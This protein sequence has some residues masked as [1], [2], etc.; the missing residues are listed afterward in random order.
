MQA[1]RLYNV[2]PHVFNFVEDLTNWYV[3]LNRRRFWANGLDEDKKAAYSTLYRAL[4]TLSKVAAPIT[5]F[6]SEH[7]FQ[8]ICEFGKQPEE[9]VHL[10]PYPE[11]DEEI[12]DAKLER[13]VSSMQ[14]VIILGRQKRDKENIK[15]KTPLSKLTIAHRDAALLSGIVDL[16]QYVK[17][18]LNIKSLVYSEDEEAL[19]ELFAKP[20]FPVLG[21]RLGKRMP[22]FKTSIEALS[23]KELQN[24]ENGESVLIDGETFGPDDINVFRKP[25][26][27]TQALSNKFITIE[28]NCELTEELI[29]EGLAR[30]VVSRIQ[31]R[32]KDKEFNISDRICVKYAT[33]THTQKLKDAIEKHKEYIMSETLAVEFEHDEKALGYTFYFEGYSLTLQ[34]QVKDT[35]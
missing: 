32:R 23:T 33:D 14:Q 31:K 27:G 19:I 10:C 26:P 5:P 15:I 6:F 7:M 22:A 24:L 29:A 13:S 9:S 16:E 8:E 30:E 34:M 3:R 18:E 17:A 25:K 28:L 12:T 2:L 35:H 11:T 20:N 21:R 1:Y 4:L